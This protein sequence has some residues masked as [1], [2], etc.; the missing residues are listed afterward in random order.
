MIAYRELLVLFSRSDAPN[1]QGAFGILCNMHQLLIFICH[2][3]IQKPY[4]CII[5]VGME[6]AFVA[7]EGMP[8]QFMALDF[9]QGA[10]R[11]FVQNGVTIFGKT[12]F[13]PSNYYHICL[14]YNPRP[15]EKVWVQ[16]R[17]FH[18]LNVNHGEKKGLIE[19]SMLVGGS[20]CIMSKHSLIPVS[21]L[22]NSSENNKTKWPF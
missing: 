19:N 5:I 22:R 11:M 20:E 21:S 6:G 13:E 7:R 10:H 17:P 16:S 9:G 8:S 4:V 2:R 15:L 3:S 1:G 12:T 18:P 14:I